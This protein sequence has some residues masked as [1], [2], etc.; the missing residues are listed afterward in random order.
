MHASGHDAPGDGAR[1][2]DSPGGDASALAG[3]PGAL[4]DLA[5]HS[6]ALIAQHQH[7]SGAYPA[8]PTFANY[9]YSWFRDGAFI[10]DAMSRAGRVTSAEAF[11]D[12]C[13][14]VLVERAERVAD[15]CERARR[16]EPVADDDLLPARFTLDGQDTGDDWWDFQTDGYGTW[17]WA[18]VA[19]ARRHEVD[20]G[21][22]RD[23]VAVATDYLTLFWDRPCFDWW[24]ENHGHRHTS[25]LGANWAGLDAAADADVLDEERAEVAREAA[26]D[27]HAFILRACVQDGRLTKWVGNDAVDGSLLACL[28]PFGLVAPTSPLAE[29]TYTVVTN[30]LL[31]RGVRRH[32]ADTF[33]GGGEWMLLTALCGLHEVRTG[34]DGFARERLAWVASCADREGHLPEQVNDETLSPGHVDEWLDRWGPVAKPL[35]WSHAMYLT[36]ALE[37]GVLHADTGAP[38][39]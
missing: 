6:A 27:V 12:W 31:H 34:R 8:S 19:H 37:S 9:R 20:L 39:A 7:A 3:D 30:Q 33:Y 29:R 16:G 36:L 11:H 18:L 35:L 22:W 10:A 14:R 4:A 13:A 38:A 26:D 2:I 28:T 23:A 24:E 15:A 25:T 5:R 17:L 32:M 21:R 1:R